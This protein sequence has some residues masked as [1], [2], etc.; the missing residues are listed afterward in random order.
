MGR[1]HQIRRELG[2]RGLVINVQGAVDH[3]PALLIADGH[4]PLLVL[5][6]SPELQVLVEEE[7]AAALP[8]LPLLVA[9]WSVRLP[10]P[11]LFLLHPGD[12]GC[13]RCTKVRHDRPRTIFV[14]F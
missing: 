3:L 8:L 7:V 9:V 6:L 4:T 2:F 5:G 12:A 13:P 1:S 14:H 10:K 11:Q